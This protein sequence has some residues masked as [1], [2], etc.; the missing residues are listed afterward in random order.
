MDENVSGIIQMM[1]AA[2]PRGLPRLDEVTVRRLRHLTR[3]LTAARPGAVAE[4][5]RFLAVTGRVLEMPEEDLAARLRG[6][7]VLVTGGTGCVGS[8]LMSQLAARRPRRLVSVS[9][10]L[11]TGWP[12]Q[13][14]AEY[15]RGDIRDGGSLA[16]LISSVRPDVVFHVAAQRDPGLAELEVHRTVSTNVLGTRNVVS[17]ALCA[18]V[19]QIVHASTGKALRPYSPDVYTASKRAAEWIMADLAAE[20]GTLCSAA[21]FTHIVDNSIVYRRL[22]AWAAAPAGVLRLHCPDIAFYTQSALESAQLLLLGLVGAQRGEFAVHAITDLGWPVSLLDLALGLLADGGSLAPLYFSGYDPGYEEVPFPGLYDPVT[23]GDVSPLVSAFEACATTTAPCAAVDTFG[24]RFAPDPRLWKLV[25]ALE[26]CCD[27]T[28]DPVLLRGTLDELSWS[29]LD[30][31]LRAA[32]PDALAR[33]ATLAKG[34]WDT[35][36][37]SHRRVLETICDLIG[38]G[39]AARA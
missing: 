14:G 36:G 37:A 34:H 3:L 12:Q 31:T 18:G 22:S 28:R 4:H 1:R 19:P 15:L 7:T 13:D 20:S 5:A 29:L 10:G 27:R 17:A 9:R 11:T 39:G 32:Q 24:L 25:S 8:A 26:A 30:A 2:A 38:S 35:M 6:A 21:R 23:A 16:K 33:S